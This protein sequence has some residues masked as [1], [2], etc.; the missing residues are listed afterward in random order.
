MSRSGP[1]MLKR[2][3]KAALYKLA[4]RWT[5]EF[6]SARAR[7]HSHRVVRAWGC[8]E[9]AEAIFS[10][11]GDRVLEGPF[12]GIQLTPMTKQEHIAPFLFGTYESELDP[13]W[14]AVLAGSYDRVIDIGSKFGYYAVGLALRFPQAVVTAFD[15]DPWAR[16]AT[17]EMMRANGT[18]NVRVEGYC[19]Q[20]N[21]VSSAGER[22]FVISDCEGYEAQ[23]FDANVA[24]S[25]HAAVMIIETH[26]CLVQGTRR[27]LTELLDHTHTV[28]T[29]GGD[30][31]R[32]V[33]DKPL[34]FLSE[35][36]RELALNEIRPEQ[37]WLIC[38]P[39]VGANADLSKRFDEAAK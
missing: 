36:Q 9:I 5:T 7:A 24:A 22:T 39:K 16:R 12:A 29:I 30:S 32:R 37:D 26:D 8:G 14:D 2:L 31:R 6:M 35:S 1:R 11:L 28:R 19:D 17:H 20:A 13:A 10:K 27:K 4:P 38:F 33:F 18:A 34:E 23:L 25:L 21:L 3:I 15:T